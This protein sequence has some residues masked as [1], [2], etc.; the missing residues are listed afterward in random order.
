MRFGN[1]PEGLCIFFRYRFVSDSE[2]SMM[3]QCPKPSQNLDKEKSLLKNP[4]DLF[5]VLNWQNEQLMRLQQQVDQLI[6]WQNQQSSELSKSSVTQPSPRTSVTQPSTPN[7]TNFSP[8][9]MVDSST[10]MSAPSSPQ[11][12]YRESRNFQEISILRSEQE[13]EKSLE[14][15]MIQPSSLPLGASAGKFASPVQKPNFAQETIEN[16]GEDEIVCQDVEPFENIEELYAN[17]RNVN[18][19]E[20]PDND[21]MGKNVNIPKEESCIEV[22]RL[23]DLGVSFISKEDLYPNRKDEPKKA[24]FDPSLWYPQAVDPFQNPTVNTTTDYSLMINSAA[25]KY[26]NDA[27]LTQVAQKS[28]QNASTLEPANVTRYGLPEGTM[29]VSTREYFLKNDLMRH[30]EK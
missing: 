3:S 17:F 5:K 29:S 23:K 18:V 12:N 14:P 9:L 11:K 6:T 20:Y 13:L 21:K 22:Q 8:K 4:E 25:L 24:D 15:S 26:L 30:E 7:L 16:F 19:T 28:P 1:F 2:P 10:Q 27:Q